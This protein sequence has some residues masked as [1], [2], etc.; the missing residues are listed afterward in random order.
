MIDNIDCMMNVNN[1]D[2]NMQYAKQQNLLINERP[3]LLS[4]WDY[5]RNE[6][7]G[8]NVSKIK[9]GSGVKAWWRCPA[10]H[11]SYGMIVYNKI[12]GQGCPYCSGKKV[13]PG[14]NDIASQRPDVMEEW[15]WAE[16][17]KNNI[18]PDALTVNSHV[19]AH[20]K[21]HEYKHDYIMSITKRTN[22]QSCPFCS[23]HRILTSFN[24]LL[25]LYPDLVKSEWDWIEND[26]RNIRPSEITAHSRIKACW[27]CNVCKGKYEATVN[28]K[29][30]S[31]HNG[32]PYC[33]SIKVLP[34]F[35]DLASCYHELIESEWNWRRNNSLKIYPNNITKYSNIKAWW[36]CS[37][38][39]H[40][41]FTTVANRTFLKRGCPECVKHE[42]NHISQQENQV[43]EYIRNYLCEHHGNISFTIH[44][45][46]SFKEIYNDKNI[47]VH[48]NAGI[49]L[50]K[51]LRKELDIYIPELS[52]AIEYDGDYW[53]SDDVM[54]S[55]TGL[56]NDETHMIK[57]SLCS[58][59]GI[60]LLF[61]SEHD[62]LNENDEIKHV[63][64]EIINK[65]IKNQND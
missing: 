59:A 37:E 30:G 57:Q 53:H 27:H 41:W 39:G 7:D 1:N 32:C 42:N 18:K 15:D 63:I 6:H 65:H 50:N 58:Q 12:K 62:W 51:H 45:S 48:N 20:W 56:T 23:S 43:A 38:C 35:N 24:D 8:I 3:D 52:L 25:T 55:K 26:K 14:F 49:D 21:C 17:N 4:E 31:N 10:H 9:T 44:R 11:H 29:T 64:N 19:K 33:A 54:L 40:E 16:N 61:I 22:G 13:L 47:H 34:G 36:I 28:S 2:D 5:A 60:D 46:I